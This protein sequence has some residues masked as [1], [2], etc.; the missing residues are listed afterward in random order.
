M[1]WCCFHDGWATGILSLL[2]TRSITAFWSFLVPPFGTGALLLFSMTVGPSIPL[3]QLFIQ[4]MIL[5]SKVFHSRSLGLYLSCKGI[6]A[7]FFSS[8]VVGCHRVSKY[9]TN[10][11]LGSG[12]MAVIIFIFS[13]RRCQLMMPKIIS[14]PHDPYVL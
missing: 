2:S 1:W 5:L 3:A 4:V 6:S 12:N 11:C 10:L 7:W 8:M 9:H 13:H 14:E